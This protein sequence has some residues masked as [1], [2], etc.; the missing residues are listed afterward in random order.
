MSASDNLS[1]EAFR[2]VLGTDKLKQPLGQHWSTDHNEPYEYIH[3]GVYGDTPPAGPHLIVEA[4]ANP[5]DDMPAE[6]SDAS[7][8]LTLKSGSKVKVTSITKVGGRQGKYG[9]KQRTRRYNPPREM[10]A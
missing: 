10:T 3:S 4:K 6:W 2:A 7:K 8:P 1:V 5:K 9:P